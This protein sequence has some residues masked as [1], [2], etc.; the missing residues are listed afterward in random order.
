MSINNPLTDN[1]PADRED[2]ALVMSA[3]SGDRRALEELMS[4]IKDGSTTSLSACSTIRRTQR[5]QRRRFS[6]KC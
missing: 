5:T 6:S 2:Q 4:A 3:R 1:A